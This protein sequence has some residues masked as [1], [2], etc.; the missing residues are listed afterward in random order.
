MPESVAV[1]YREGVSHGFLLLR[2]PDGKPIADGE[3]TQVSQGDRVTTHM[4][5]KFKDGSFYDQTTVFSQRGTFHLLR[6]HVLREG[7]AFKRRLETS[8]DATSGEV[9]VRYTDDHNQEKVTS[10]RL[11]LPPDVANGILFTLLK[12]VQPDV[13]KTTVSYVAATPKP[14]LVNLEITPQGQKPFSIGSYNHKALLYSVKVRIG[15]IAGAI[16]SLIGKQPPDTQAW[17]LTGEAPAFARADGPL[18]GDGPIV[19]MELAI[20]AVWPDSGATYY[21]PS[22]VS[23]SMTFDSTATRNCE[24][25]LNTTR[26]KRINTM[27]QFLDYL[28]NDAMPALIDRLAARLPLICERQ[29]TISGEREILLGPDANKQPFHRTFRVKGE[30]WLA[31]KSLRSSPRQR[32]IIYAEEFLF[33]SF[34][35]VHD[36]PCVIVQ[37]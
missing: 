27:T 9:T 21:V 22:N 18:Y 6:D 28:T 35:P 20:P 30:S 11:E 15:G 16:A 2:T 12:N 23:S 34:F 3:S 14:R 24:D 29:S 19:R 10:K 37:L 8:I 25:Q 5:F 1:R 26:R 17:V 7:P 4:W 33:A 31:F 13:P 32:Y 36:N